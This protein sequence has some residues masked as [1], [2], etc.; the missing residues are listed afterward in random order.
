MQVVG[1]HP[2][3]SRE[4]AAASLT[5]CRRVW[6]A[7]G[8]LLRARVDQVALNLLVIAIR[9][10]LELDSKSPLLTMDSPVSG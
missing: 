3:V 2:T 10:V 5:F 8:E 6:G 7:G 1:A 9:S 4:E